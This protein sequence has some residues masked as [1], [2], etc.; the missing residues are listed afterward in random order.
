MKVKNKS[1][2]YY[3]LALIAVVVG[4]LVF[5]LKPKRA[6]K[7]EGGF[8]ASIGQIARPI[9]V[10]EWVRTPEA[11]KQDASK[12]IV[13]FAALRG[14][15]V[16]LERWATWCGPCVSKIPKLIE[17][18]KKHVKDLAVISLTDE[19]R[20]IVEKFLGATTLKSI[21][22][23]L[24]DIPLAKAANYTI[25]TVDLNDDS[26]E[27]YFGQ[28][29]GVPSFFII[30]RDGS[31]QRAV[32]GSYDVVLEEI[33][34]LLEGRGRSEEEEHIAKRLLEIEKGRGRLRK[35][36]KKLRAAH[37]AS[38]SGAARAAVFA[39]LLELR[40]FLDETGALKGEDHDLRENKLE[41][42]IE[43]WRYA[44]P[45][46]K[47]KTLVEISMKRKLIFELLRSTTSSSPDWNSI[48]WPLVAQDHYDLL[49]AKMGLEAVQILLRKLKNEP[50]NQRV[51]DY[52]LDTVAR[53]YHIN[54]D[55]KNAI[56]YQREA[57]EAAIPF[58]K[59]MLTA[60]L[61]YYEA[62]QDLRDSRAASLAAVRRR[63]SSAD[64]L[65]PASAGLALPAERRALDALNENFRKVEKKQR[66]EAARGIYERRLALLSAGGLQ[67]RDLHQALAA[68]GRYRRFLPQEEKA[69]GQKKYHALLFQVRRSADGKPE[70]LNAFARDLLFGE[71]YSERHPSLALEILETLGERGASPLILRAE[72][73]FQLGDIEESL[74]L[75]K[76]AR[77][78]G[79]TSEQLSE[80]DAMTVHHKML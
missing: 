58:R 37:K 22:D 64:A 24:P 20:E 61:G 54:G 30:G 45:G 4:I 80:I 78:E 5:S 66:L 46:G 72:L 23:H 6:E 7:G 19:S 77:G 28:L 34:R 11:G 55:F 38:P 16:L 14:K 33:A 25:G 35:K 59:A 15:I 76:E 44:G 69:S 8:T 73:A 41:N 68:F 3:A 70:F 2:G 75:L 17:L 52:M 47:S 10:E 40:G 32:V 74:K 65:P 26:V 27:T 31:L 50:E 48:A 12:P 1:T 29:R 79:P 53:A 49:D 57:A 18:Q 67:Y 62:L 63:I 51:K 36:L 56:E 71:D 21:D 42:L 60:T 9:A 43:Q 39:A 13:D